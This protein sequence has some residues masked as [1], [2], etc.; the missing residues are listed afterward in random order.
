ALR[1]VPVP[2]DAGWGED[3]NRLQRLTHDVGAEVMP[4]L[5]TLLLARALRFAGDDAGAERLLRAAIRGRP[6][7][8][9]YYGALAQRLPSQS[10]PRWAEAAECYTAA[11]ALRPELGI[12]LSR[13]Q[14]ESGRTT[15]ALALRR[16][17][18]RKQPENPWLRNSLGFLLEEQGRYAEAEGLY[19]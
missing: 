4:P 19:Q 13:A 8:G 7:E 5:T 9:I 14:T 12:S 1:P 17:L 11:R 3:R 6:G 15:D 18:L 2:F 10:P 16:E